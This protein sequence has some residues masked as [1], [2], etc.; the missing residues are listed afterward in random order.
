MPHPHRPPDVGHLRI[1][2]GATGPRVDISRVRWI[3]PFHLAGLAAIAHG[4]AGRGQTLEVALPETG[5]QRLYAARMRLGRTLT[6]AGVHHDLPRVNE[7]RREDDLLEVHAIADEDGAARLAR[8]VLMRVRRRSD[9]GAAGADA[10]LHAGVFEMADNVV[11]HAG[12]IGFVAAQVLPRAGV[13]RFAIADSGLGLLGTLRSRG[14]TDHHDAARKALS[15]VSRFADPGHGQGLRT[16]VDD[17]SRRGG[18]LDVA[19]GDALTHA[20]SGIIRSLSARAAYRGTL[21]VGS[22]DLA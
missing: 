7:R 19:S 11:R 15:G 10:A 14:A 8:L 20:R 13:V 2:D 22:L 17:V 18:R 5:D 21:V 16:T 12:C 6:D 9:R 4:A 3:D 1:H